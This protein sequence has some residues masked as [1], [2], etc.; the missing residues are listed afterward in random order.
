MNIPVLNVWDETQKKYVGI[1]AISGGGGGKITQEQLPAGYPW[2][3]RT[4]IEWD[5]NTEGREVVPWL[6]GAEL[7]KV[8]DDTP[9]F[10][11]L[12]GGTLTI[13][14]EAEQQSVPLNGDSMNPMA[15]FFEGVDGTIILSGYAIVVYSPGSV[16]VD[17]ET[18]TFQ[19]KGTYFANLAS[20]GINFY[21]LEY[22]TTTPISETLLPESVK[23]VVVNFTTE[24][25]ETWTVDKTYA[26]IE[27]AILS[28]AEVVAKMEM[29]GIMTGYLPLAMYSAADSMIGATI[30]FIGPSVY[31]KMGDQAG[32][33]FD[34]L[35][36]APDESVVFDEMT[37]VKA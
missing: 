2:D 33:N 1:P 3:G 29:T 14:T 32:I 20:E 12:S 31:M 4:V 19:S 34:T 30:Q 16:N 17:G 36:L 26:E 15:N 18:I 28:G 35:S 6:D 8:S 25:M 7:V 10:A 22:R 9:S 11:I 37:L 23:R 21:S 13:G 27:A 5:G 24:D